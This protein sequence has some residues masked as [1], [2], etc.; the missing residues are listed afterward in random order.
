MRRGNIYIYIYIS[1]INFIYI[2]IYVHTYIHTHTHTHIYMEE[3]NWGYSTQEKCLS[4]K[5]HILK[6]QKPS[7]RCRIPPLDILDTVVPETPN[8]TVYFHYS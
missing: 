1:Y 4:Q 2:Y 3:F 5:S 7:A 6:N 8:N